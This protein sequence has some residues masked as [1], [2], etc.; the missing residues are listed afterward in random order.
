MAAL[1]STKFAAPPHV[2]DLILIEHLLLKFAPMGTCPHT[3]AGLSA[4]FETRLII[5][6]IRSFADSGGF[7]GVGNQR[8]GI[9]E[10]GLYIGGLSY[11]PENS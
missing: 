4:D 5:T 8:K 6:T 7:I 1:S 9:Q 2:A 3:E 10:A 11:S